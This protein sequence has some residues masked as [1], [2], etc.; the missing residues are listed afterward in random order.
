M[1]KTRFIWLLVSTLLILFLAGLYTN[2]EKPNK[3][4]QTIQEGFRTI[5]DMKGRSFAVADPIQRI[6]L[7][8]G[9]TGQVAFIL[10]VQDRLC[11]VTNTLKMSKL[12]REMYPNIEHLPGPP[13]HLGQH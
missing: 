8:G 9:P 6:A 2:P 7:L 11:A 13:D 3:N 4:D 5:T 1:T 10:G 12:V